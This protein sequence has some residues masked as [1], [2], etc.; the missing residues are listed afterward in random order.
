[1]Q[2]Y[3][4]GWTDIPE[5]EVNGKKVKAS[6]SARYKAL[7]NSIALPFWTWMFERMA[8]GS[9]QYPGFFTLH[10]LS[11]MQKEKSEGKLRMQH[12]WRHILD[13]LCFVLKQDAGIRQDAFTDDF[14]AEKLANVL[15]SL[16]LS[17]LL[18][19]DYDPTAILEIIRRLLY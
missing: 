6:D 13:V 12:A 4:D 15:F 16:M 2:G 10:S 19:E 1:M 5:T 11:F 14:T 18:R 7:G 17:A 9:R 3:P 8:Y